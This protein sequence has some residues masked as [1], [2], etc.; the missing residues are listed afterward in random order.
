M[1]DTTIKEIIIIFSNLCCVK[2]ITTSEETTV[3]LNIHAFQEVVLW[4]FLLFFCVKM[5][6]E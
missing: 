2:N 4:S 1:Q 5:I 6:A 3:Y